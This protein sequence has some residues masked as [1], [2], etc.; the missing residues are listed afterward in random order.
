MKIPISNIE[1]IP[2]DFAALTPGSEGGKVRSFDDQLK[3]LAES[4]REQGQL[5]PVIVRSANSSPE[6]FVLV[7]GEKRVRAAQLLG[8]ADV[9]ATVRDDLTD[10]SAQI[11]EVHENLRRFNL[12][13]YEEV[14]LVNRLH[15]LKQEEHGTPKIGRPRPDDPV[16]G[17]G[18]RETAEELGRALG[19]VSEDLKLA[20]AVRLDPA[21]RNVKDKKTAIK[22][23]RIHAQ[24]V[25]TETEAGL[26]ISIEADQAFLGDSTAILKQ[27]PA[28]TFD[29]VIT[30]PPWL[31]FFDTTL[32]RDS[33]TLPVFREVFR[34]MKYN[35][36][37]Y[38]F[39]GYDD[40]VYYTGYDLMDEVG[41]ITHHKGELEKIGFDIAQTPLFWRK[42]NALSR[43]GVRAWEYDRDFEIIIVAAKGTPVLTSSTRR[44]AFKDFNAVPPVK[45]IHPNEKP[46]DLIE[47]ILEDCSYQGHLVLDPFGGSFS[48]PK[49]CQRTGRRFIVCE[50]DPETYNRGCRRIGKEVK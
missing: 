29:A 16:T 47:A 34:T 27:F 43:R 31:K 4:M 20:R 24:R 1:F 32:A 17:W 37:M 2:T 49:A 7:A 19:Q 14:E 26:P 46:L 33:R 8:W 12:P 44:S 50:R 48:T 11:L 9:E 40:L 18:I 22:L 6:H 25:Q 39:C 5:H 45:L 30:D 36:L 15:T 42:G 21:L 3:D 23:V 38:L 10:K 13:W 35:T 28:Q 41:N